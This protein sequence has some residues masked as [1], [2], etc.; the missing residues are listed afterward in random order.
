MKKQPSKTPLPWVAVCFV[1]LLVTVSLSGIF[2]G[3]DSPPELVPLSDKS[4][5]TPLVGANPRLKALHQQAALQS[6]L[7]HGLRIILEEVSPEISGTP[8]PLAQAALPKPP[9][10]TAPA[11]VLHTP[12]EPYNEPPAVVLANLT[13][14][15]MSLTS[16]QAAD[17]AFRLL[18]SLA[19]FLHLPISNLTVTEQSDCSAVENLPLE[20]PGPCPLP[21]DCKVQEFVCGKTGED[22]K[23]V[24]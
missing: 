13:L 8:S 24:L 9:G 6:S 1:V 20:G 16:F 23:H 15:G 4:Q 3:N 2:L 14:L 18:Q 17:G 22:S 19:G 12:R 11:Q 5:V 21:V 10:A 7:K